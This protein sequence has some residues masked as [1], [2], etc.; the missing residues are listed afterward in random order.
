M[1]VVIFTI[2]LLQSLTGPVCPNSVATSSLLQQTTSVLPKGSLFSS[3]LLESN[4]NRNEETFN[5]DGLKDR[6]KR[7]NDAKEYLKQFVAK[8]N[9]QYKYGSDEF[10]AN[11]RFA[12]FLVSTELYCNFYY[13]A[14]VTCSLNIVVESNLF[15][16][17]LA[18]II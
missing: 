15:L 18:A 12:I 13:T 7:V 14:F 4:R 11:S 6:K 1:A 3:S 10:N 9:K 2:L 5:D 17:C 16:T 8:L